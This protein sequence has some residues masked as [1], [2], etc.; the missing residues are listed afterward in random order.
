M[1]AET[2]RITFTGRDGPGITAA[3][4]AVLAAKSAQLFDVEQVVVQGFLTLGFAVGFA[5]KVEEEDA[6]KELLFVA[7]K[8]GLQ[9]E[10]AAP[11]DTRTLALQRFALTA[12]AQS[13][14]TF[15]LRDIATTL[16]AYGAN[17]ERIHRLSAAGLACVEL[18]LSLPPAADSGALKRALLAVAG[19]GAFDVALQEESLLRRSKRLVVMDMDSTLIQ[20]EVIDELAREYGVGEQVAAITRRAMQGELDFD[21]SLRERVALLR[22]MDVSVLDRLAANLPLTEGAEVLLRVLKRLGY[23]TAV[24]SGGFS[25]A[26]QALRKRLGIDLAWSNTLEVEGGKLTGRVVGPIVNAQRKAELLEEVALREGIPLDQVIAI[27]DGANDLLMLQKAG[28]G[29]AFHA[30]PKLREAADTA[31]SGAGLDAIL[32]LLGIGWRDIASL[33]KLDPEL[34]SLNAARRSRSDPPPRHG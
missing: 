16:A 7:R 11:L 14:G 15:A 3:I 12:I 33:E 2:L 10:Y 19:A 5:G 30:K 26:A 22:G 8:Q 27:G 29:I 4:T 23:R 24:I 13:L 31:I 34:G 32:Y 17:I 28:H 1:A 9:M 6:L 20:I 21:Q 18:S 25:V